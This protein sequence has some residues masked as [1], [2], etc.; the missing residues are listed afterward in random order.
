MVRQSNR[1]ILSKGKNYVQ[2]QAKKFGADE[3]TFDRDS[4]LEYLTGFHKRKV[5]RQK[6]A[7]EFA[8]EQERQNKIEERRKLREQRKQDAEEQFTKFKNSMKEVG[9]YIGSDGEDE[10]LRVQP[11]ENSD[12]EGSWTGFSD[13][14][15]STNGVKPI[16][17][18]TRDVYDDDTQ[19]DIEPLE[20][21][22][23]FEYLARA[24]NVRLERSEK[25]LDESIDRAAKYAKFLG[26]DDKPKKKKKFRY[27][28]KAERRENQRKANSNKRRK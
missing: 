6:K 10:S 4:R 24:N 5:E 3:V 2:K 14:G 11:G 16:L 27:L 20:P 12:N 26:M 21:N 1:E 7:Q 15:D 8:K 18:R 9:D 23:N 19:V 17:K 22:D 13:D 25:I 28:T